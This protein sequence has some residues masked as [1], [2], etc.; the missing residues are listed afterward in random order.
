MMKKIVQIII[1]FTILSV[2]TSCDQLEDIIPFSHDLEN[3]IIIEPIS[4]VGNMLEITSEISATNITTTLNDY[5]T[6]ENLVDQIY[7]KNCTLEINSPSDGDFSFLEAIAIYIQ[8]EGLPAKKIAWSEAIPNTN[9]FELITTEEDIKDYLFQD[10]YSLYIAAQNDEIT[11]STYYITIRTNLEIN[12][13]FIG[14]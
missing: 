11:T 12:A 1:L 14:D 10:N 9:G 8:V 6:Q 4:T 5:N 3:T 7:L 13:Q 2:T